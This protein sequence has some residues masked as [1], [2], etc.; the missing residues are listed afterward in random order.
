MKFRQP[1]FAFGRIVCLALLI[2]GTLAKSTVGKALIWHQHGCFMAHF[3][4]VGP[5]DGLGFAAGSPAFGHRGQVG[6]HSGAQGVRPILIITTGLVFVSEDRDHAL[7][8][9]RVCWFSIPGEI[10]A[11]PH[12][13]RLVDSFA[14]VPAPQ[15]RKSAATSLLLRNHSLL[16]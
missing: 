16:I 11:S 5:G 13:S 1:D 12:R 10:L 15:L 8:A 6:T 9:S 2:A 7:P 4:V 3:H 14:I